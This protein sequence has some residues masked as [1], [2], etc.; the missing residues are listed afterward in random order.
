[1]S[2]LVEVL[3]SSTRRFVASLLDK[4]AQR[5]VFLVFTLRTT[6]AAHRANANDPILTDLDCFQEVCIREFPRVAK[7]F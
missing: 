5:F 4:S 3:R 1:V 7:R 6:F 2:L